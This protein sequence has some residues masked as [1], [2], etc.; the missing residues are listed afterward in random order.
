MDSSVPST[1]SRR[2]RRSDRGTKGNVGH[3]A[4]R[5]LRPH[6][7]PPPAA[8]PA[9]RRPFLRELWLRPRP[10]SSEDKYP[11]PALPGP[12]RHPQCPPACP[13][14]ARPR[15]GLA[16]RPGAFS[17]GSLV[18]LSS[19]SL[20]VPTRRARPSAPT[21]PAVSG[22]A[23]ERPGAAPAALTAA[24]IPPRRR[25]E[26]PPGLG[27]WGAALGCPSGPGDHQDFPTRDVCFP[28]PAATCHTNPP[29]NDTS[30]HGRA[31][32]EG[33][34]AARGRGLTDSR[35]SFRASCPLL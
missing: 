22:H 4:S 8:S 11:C 6:P 5:L 7:G 23:A 31:G 12:G 33:P 13:R 25:S 18:P 29:L 28:L 10:R 32:A 26:G 15:A 14:E 19:V 1:R 16:P 30:G 24:G 34:C 3:S 21:T 20:L 35:S 2:G 27:S 17:I 9:G